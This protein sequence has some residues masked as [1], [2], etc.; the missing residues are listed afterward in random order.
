VQGRG[1]LSSVSAARNWRAG[2]G[3][4]LDRPSR[5]G[6]FSVLVSSRLLNES[7][8]C[9]C[10]IGRWFQE[11]REIKRFAYGSFNEFKD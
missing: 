1:R 11:L 3:T 8:A 4:T 9:A 10:A 2:L 5:P 6:S 7:L